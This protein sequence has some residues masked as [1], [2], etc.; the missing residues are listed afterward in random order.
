MKIETYNLTAA[1]GRHIR[2]ATQVT[3]DN[4][5]KIRLIERCTKKEILKML[6]RRK[7]E[8]E[9]KKWGRMLIN[10]EKGLPFFK[11]RR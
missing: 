8:A 7:Q 6:E 1:N 4:G 5:K 2:K 10:M 9:E 3:I 11:E